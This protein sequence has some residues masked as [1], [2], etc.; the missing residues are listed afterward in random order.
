MIPT[1]N[2]PNSPISGE[3]ID[4]DQFMKWR[5]K[6]NSID[7]TQN[8]LSNSYADIVVIAQVRMF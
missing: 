3:K 8:T 5:V 6:D 4:S 7:K 2:K 1:I